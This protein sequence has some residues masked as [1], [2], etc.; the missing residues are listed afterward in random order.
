MDSFLRNRLAFSL[1]I[2]ESFRQSGGDQL[3]QEGIF[4]VPHSLAST[5]RRHCRTEM[6]KKLEI[7]LSTSGTSAANTWNKHSVNRAV[8][9]SGSIL[10]DAIFHGCLD[11]NP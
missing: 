6:G 1:G 4:G 9:D 8:V 7:M 11:H 10:R 3:A 2:A 5:Q